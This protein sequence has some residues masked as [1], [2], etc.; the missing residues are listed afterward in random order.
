MTARP[1]IAAAL[2]DAAD[3]R[4]ERATAGPCTPCAEAQGRY[5][6]EH[7]GD[8]DAAAAYRQASA[9]LEAAG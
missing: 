8:L 1:V 5:C 7:E 6:A 9:E 4:T 2:E 3:Y